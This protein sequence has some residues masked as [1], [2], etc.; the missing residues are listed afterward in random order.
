MPIDASIWLGP[1]FDLRVMAS[2]TMM[3]ALLLPLLAVS[4]AANAGR[5]LKVETSD[6]GAPVVSVPYTEPQQY[7]E[8]GERADGWGRGPAS[9]KGTLRY[10]ML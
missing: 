5:Q 4:A 6:F 10:K 9:A 2:K 1:S 3:A 8:Y 7:S